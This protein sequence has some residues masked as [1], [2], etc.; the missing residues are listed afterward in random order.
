[1]KKILLTGLGIIICSNAFAAMH[2]SAKSSNFICDPVSP[3]KVTVNSAH[4]SYRDNIPTISVEVE[5]QNH[6]RMWIEFNENDLLVGTQFLSIAGKQAGVECAEKNEVVS[7]SGV[8]AFSD[9][10]KW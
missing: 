4:Y 10:N 6:Y 7:V 5:D 8:Y 9:K 2:V 1:M 3:V